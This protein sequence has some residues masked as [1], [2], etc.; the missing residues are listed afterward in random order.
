LI[1]TYLVA[2]KLLAFFSSAVQSASFYNHAY[3]TVLT[4]FR[5][6]AS[7]CQISLNHL[8]KKPSLN[9]KI[10]LPIKYIPIDGGHSQSL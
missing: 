6:F 1:Q 9:L 5:E 7:V 3:L 2:V 8:S 4:D 10:S